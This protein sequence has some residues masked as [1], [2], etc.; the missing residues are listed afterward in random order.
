M[1]HTTPKYSNMASIKLKFRPSTTDA[2]RGVI[3]IEVI[4]NRVVRQLRT[5]YR[6]YPSEWDNENSDIILSACDET[7]KDTL[8]EILQGIKSDMAC[9]YR[10]IHLLDSSRRPYTADQ[11]VSLFKEI[12]Y[13]HLCRIL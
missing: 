4:H 10:I 2:R 3:F 8:I 7:R 5:T 11:I 9:L 13:S 12:L 1:L 6:V